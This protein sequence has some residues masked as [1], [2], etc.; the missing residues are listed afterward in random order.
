MT[1]HCLQSIDMS[2]PAAADCWHAQHLGLGKAEC[3]ARLLLQHKSH[4]RQTATAQRIMETIIIGCIVIALVINTWAFLLHLYSITINLARASWCCGIRPACS[5]RPIKRTKLCGNVRGHHLS[6]DGRQWPSFRSTAP[7]IQPESWAYEERHPGSAW[8]G[9]AMVRTSQ[10]EGWSFDVSSPVVEVAWSSSPT[11]YPEAD[12][13]W[14]TLAL[15]WQSPAISSY[16]P[17]NNR[18]NEEGGQSRLQQ[19]RPEGT[20]FLAND[21]VYVFVYYTINKQDN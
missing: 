19:N 2:E 10:P 6:Q 5:F 11:T 3:L 21:E 18:L 8:S 9:C 16:A 15:I 12:C 20:L 17:Q 14:S 1:F 13:T 4:T 7:Q